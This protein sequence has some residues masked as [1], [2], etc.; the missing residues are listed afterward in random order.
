MADHSR[1]M[2]A[3]ILDAELRFEELQQIKDLCLILND[4]QNKLFLKGCVLT[5]YAHW[6]GFAKYSILE[7][8]KYI[9]NLN[10]KTNEYCFNY[11]TFAYESG[12][13]DLD[14]SQGFDKRKRHLQ[15]L[16]KNLEKQTL[17]IETRIDTNSNLNFKT[18]SDICKKLNIKINTEFEKTYKKDINRLVSIRNAIAHGEGGDALEF[19]KFEDIELYLNLLENLALDFIT[20]L[21]NLLEQKNYKRKIENEQSI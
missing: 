10:I 14:K 3:I 8:I 7:T 6:E 16:Y 21:N 4:S 13:K 15:N 9:N 20:L 1:V 18:L 5:I 11:I 17:D 19:S 2:E 12:L